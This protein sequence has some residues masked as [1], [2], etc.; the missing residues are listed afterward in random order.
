MKKLLLPLA[1]STLLLGACSKQENIE[2]TTADSAQQEAENAV[3]PLQKSGAG[4]QGSWSFC[5]DKTL[6]QETVI[7]S[8][9]LYDTFIW[10]FDG[11]NITV[12]KVVKPLVTQDCTTQCYNAPLANV[13]VNNLASGTYSKEP[14]A[15]IVDITDSNDL[16]NF[17]KCQVRW[18]IIQELD[19]QHQQWQLENVNCATAIYDFKTWVK[20]LN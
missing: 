1:V 16:V 3:T 12:G 4:I 17:P 9:T 20:K 14:D 10:Q 8:C 2:L 15:I 6:T 5:H 13:K 11:D 19:A 18:N 7:E